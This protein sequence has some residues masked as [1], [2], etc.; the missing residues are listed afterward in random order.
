MSFTLNHKP[1]TTYKRQIQLLE[2]RGLIISDKEKALDI[3]SCL[4]YYTFTGYLHDFKLDGNNYIKGT[5]FEKI[6]NIIAFDRRFRN[7][8][9][10]VLE[11]IESTLKTKIFY[12][13]AHNYGPTGYLEAENFKDKGKHGIFIKR[14]EENKDK[15][16]NLPFIKHHNKKYGGILPIW[17]A[18]EIFT[19]GMVFHF[20]R[21][22]PT[23][24][25]KQIAYEFNTG[26]N[27]L[28]S[29]LE[30]IVY[31]RNMVA[32]YMRIYNFRLQKTPAKCKKNHAFS[33]TT[34]M[35][36]DTIYIMMFLTLN[37]EEWNNYIIPNIDA[38]FQQYEGHIDIRCLGFP[39][40]WK[41]ILR[42]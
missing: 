41:E 17:V 20:Y 28:S 26:P 19:L 21:N 10:Y 38:L 33:E 22:I 18:S 36:F 40:N 2:E 8:L 23:K 6:Y 5:T 39:D 29:W 11:I 1:A 32:H 35:I 25:Q 27:Q 3:L 31:T 9:M 42:K 24:S 13:F 34:Y 15:N 16:K 12:N 4:N 14:L 7:I 37:K 30:N